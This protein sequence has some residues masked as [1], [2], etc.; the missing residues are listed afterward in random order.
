MTRAI[1]VITI[2]LLAVPAFAQQKPV[3]PIDQF[4]AEWS[5]LDSSINAASI[6]RHHVVK[7]AQA[8][9]ETMQKQTAE[10]T[11]WHRWIGGEKKQWGE[12][13]VKSP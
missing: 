2:C 3:D 5:A 13:Q 7:A 10:L 8:L 12:P 1:L 9:I 11:Y 6:E 4:G